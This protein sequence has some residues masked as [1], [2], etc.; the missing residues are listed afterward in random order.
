MAKRFE[1]TDA[2]GIRPQRLNLDSRRRNATTES[3][4]SIRRKKNR[5]AFPEC[6]KANA[7]F[8]AFDADPVM[9]LFFRKLDV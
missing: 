1:D 2:S 9:F 7:V 5:K 4:L 8:L 6:D 3:S